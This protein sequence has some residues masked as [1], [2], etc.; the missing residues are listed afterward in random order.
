MP[1]FVDQ[2]QPSREPARSPRPEPPPEPPG[3]D[4]FVSRTAVTAP[5]ELQQRSGKGRVLPGSP[6]PVRFPPDVKAALEF[7][8]ESDQRSQQQILERVAFP[9]ILE[10][11]RRQ[12]A[13]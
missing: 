2:K 5:P 6:M 4:A 8:A 7:L 10:A 3:L 13:S 11:A 12:K 1:K 9:A